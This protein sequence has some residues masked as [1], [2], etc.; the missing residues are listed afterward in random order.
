MNTR[1]SSVQTLFLLGSFLFS[2]LLLLYATQVIWLQNLGSALSW[3]LAHGEAVLLFWVLCST[4]SLTI[5]GFTRRMVL[6]YLPQAVIF[7]TLALIS[8]YKFAINGAPLQLSDFSFVGNMGNLATYAGAQLVPTV[9][10]ICAVLLVLALLMLLWRME[11]WRPTVPAGFV[12]GSLCMV[13]FF[14]ALHPG[15]LQASAIQL[16]QGCYDQQERSDQLGVVL[17]LY[18][19][20][21]QRLSVGYGSDDTMNAQMTECF[22]EEALSPAKQTPEMAPD[23]IFV[24]S[25]SF[26]DVTRLPELTFE[27]DPVPV[28]HALSETCTNGRFLSNTYGGGTGNVEME[29]FTGLTASLLRE[30]DS[31]TTLPVETYAQ[32][33]TTVRHLKQYGYQTTALHASTDELYHRRTNYPGIGFD[34]VLFVEDFI[35]PPHIS[36]QYVSDLSFAEEIIARYESRDPAV[37]QFIYG[38]SMENHQSYT[39]EKYGVASGFPAQSDK[40][41][42]EDL[43]ILDS[44]VMGLH[45]ADASLGRLVQYFSQVNRPVLLVFVGD[46]LPSLNLS[47]GTSLYQRLGISPGGDSS[48]WTAQTLVEM[49][50]T[51]YLIWSNYEAEPQPDRTESCTML[52]LRTLER[53]GLPLDGYFA[54]L[55]ETVSPHLLLSRNRLFV[56]ADGTATDDGIPVLSQDVLDIYAAVERNLLYHIGGLQP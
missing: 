36:G 47:D 42:T 26:F 39:P 16:E 8:Y 38:M 2:P 53:A 45:A 34:E 52:G 33:P 40:L 4:L 29:M 37:P 22:R 50:S 20:W 41:S 7:I 43:A 30:G 19:A 44:L 56:D 46:H 49:L 21:S 55:Q 6:A 28:F 31:L 14:S 3:M 25:E 15:I 17:G 11:R 54:W 32:I 23:I 10:T 1:P 13:L 18:S 48:D 35:T 9:V 5:Y 51:D 12:L 27:Q 24:T